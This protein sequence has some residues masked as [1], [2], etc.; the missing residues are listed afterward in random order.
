MELT[1]PTTLK[2]HDFSDESFIHGC[3][4]PDHIC[5]NL[6]KYFDKHPDRQAIGKIYDVDRKESIEDVSK[7]E[8]IEIGFYVYED[9]EDAQLL[10]EYLV[11]LNLC[12]REYEYKYDRARL[13]SS[14]GITEGINLQ[15]YEPGG[16]YKNWHAD[17][18]GSADESRSLVF[19][20][21]LNNVSEGGTEFMY[22]KIT[23][24]AK[25]GLTIIWP[26][27][28]THTHRGQISQTHQKYILTGWLNYTK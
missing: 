1:R 28:W 26:T 23:S 9:E 24:P 5:D 22:Q 13:M 17:R 12:I 20:T 4:I 2:L 19:M 25:K 11:Y 8:S 7:K 18:C 10:S 3:Y 16:G 14:Y 6:I 21:Y 27:D 15:K